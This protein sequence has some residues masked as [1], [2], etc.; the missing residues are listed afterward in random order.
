M[1]VAEVK[2]FAAGMAQIDRHFDNLKLCEKSRWS[3]PQDHPDVVPLQEALILKEGLRETRR[4][5]SAGRDERF[6][7]WLTEAE[8]QAEALEPAIKSGRADQPGR[9]FKLLDTTC[10]QCHAA[11][12]NEP[13]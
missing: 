7:R 8:V 10:K 13:K 5:L 12:R 4:T 9:Q 11:Y 1:E 3:T 2:S 6:I